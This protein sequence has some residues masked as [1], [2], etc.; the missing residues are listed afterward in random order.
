MVMRTRCLILLLIGEHWLWRSTLL[1]ANKHNF[2]ANPISNSANASKIIQ[3]MS[4]VHK[5]NPG[6]PQLLI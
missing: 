6:N 4:Y 1:D 2:G 5:N 3:H